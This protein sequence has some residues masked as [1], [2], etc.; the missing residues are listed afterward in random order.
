MPAKLEKE[1]Q[2]PLE[3]W[4]PGV[5]DIVWAPL[6]SGLLMLLV[7]VLGI[8]TGRPWLIPSLGP[9]SY[10]QAAMPQQ[11]L[12]RVYNIIVGH[13]AGI[14]AGWL[15]LL[16]VGAQGTPTLMETHHAVPIRFYAGAVAVALDLFGDLVLKAKHPP[17]AA[18]TLLIALGAFGRVFTLQHAVNIAICVALLAVV[19][20][21]LRAARVRQRPFGLKLKKA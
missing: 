15:G 12:T 11:P 16:I 20:E 7:G 10:M 18:T 17:A 14:A 21:F 1:A 8:I 3:R 4:P 13:Y 9:T 5:P 2:T 6:T 19:G